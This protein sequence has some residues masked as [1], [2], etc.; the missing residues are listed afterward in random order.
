MPSERVKCSVCLN[1][2]Y[3]LLAFSRCHADR[4]RRSPE[5]QPL[6]QPDVKPELKFPL[7]RIEELQLQPGAV[8]GTA[9]ELLLHADQLSGEPGELLLPGEAQ[10]RRE[11]AGFR[12]QVSVPDRELRF[13]AEEVDPERFARYAGK[14]QHPGSFVPVR[15]QEVSPRATEK[16]AAP[17]SANVGVGDKFAVLKIERQHIIDGIGRL[18]VKIPGQKPE[19]MFIVPGVEAVIP[20]VIPVVADRSAR[21]RVEKFPVKHGSLLQFADMQ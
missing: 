19:V 6:R 3:Q 4:F 2:E 9:D 16:E 5:S 1:R 17:R 14:H 13:I 20:E 15:Q 11:W 21:P 10:G 8:A 12:N 7:S 18:G